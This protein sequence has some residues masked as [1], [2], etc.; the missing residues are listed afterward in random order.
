MKLEKCSDTT[1]REL[2]NMNLE[3]SEIIVKKYHKVNHVIPESLQQEL[4]NFNLDV[5]KILLGRK[6]PILKTLFENKNYE[7]R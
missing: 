3:I 6:S 4:K 2:Q 5:H 7:N 1:L